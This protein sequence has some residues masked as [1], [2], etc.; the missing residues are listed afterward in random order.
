MVKV[1]IND[2]LTEFKFVGI[3]TAGAGL[4][5]TGSASI[6][7][8]QELQLISGSPPVVREKDSYQALLHGA[9]TA[10]PSR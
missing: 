2:S 3:A 6:R 4:F 8:R 10:R 1:P 9:A 5:G 7:T